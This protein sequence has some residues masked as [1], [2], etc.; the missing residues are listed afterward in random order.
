MGS[1]YRYPV[2]AFVAAA[3]VPEAIA[4]IKTF[5]LMGKSQCAA[6]RRRRRPSLTGSRLIESPRRRWQ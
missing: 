6:C 2:A 1:R 3:A 5:A 4:Q